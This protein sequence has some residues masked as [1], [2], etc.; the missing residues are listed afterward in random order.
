MA[1]RNEKT[2]HEILLDFQT[3]LQGVG[4]SL[5]VE[6]Q[7]VIEQ[8]DQAVLKTIIDDL[9]SSTASVKEQ[10][11]AL[12][13][14]VSKIEAV[15]KAGFAKAEKIAFAAGPE[16][17]KKAGATAGKLADNR[18]QILKKE[19]PKKKVDEILDYHPVDGKSISQWFHAMQ[20][21]DLERITQAVQ[22]ATVE[23]LSAS[24]AIKAIRGTKENDYKDGVLEASK[25]S[26]AM[27]ARTIVNGIAANAMLETCAENAEVI[28][29]VKFLA[30]LDAKTCP[31]CGAYDGTVWKPNELDKVK[32]PPLH[33][34]CRCVV[35]PYV[36]VKGLEG[37]RPA[38]NA[39]FDR[40][41]EEAY[42]KT[43]REKG[44]ERRYA[45]LSR[46]TRLRYYY[47][48]QKRFEKETGKPAYSRVSGDLTFK[49]Y[50]EKQPEEFK[51]SWLGPKRYELYSRG[52]YDPLQLANPDSGYLVPLEKLAPDQEGRK[53]IEVPQRK[54]QD[55]EE[56][57]A[58]LQVI[59][60]LGGSTAPVLAKDARGKKFVVKKGGK[61]GGDPQG[62]V[63]NEFAAD[64]FYRA[65]G[66]KV[67]GSRLY[68]TKDG[69]VL[70]SEYLDDG[71]ELS[72]WWREASDED[73]D[74]MLYRLR[75][76]LAAD[77]LIGNSDVIG[78]GADNI[79]V[80]KNGVPWRIDNGG[81]LG[82]TSKGQRKADA[83]WKDGYPDDLWTMTGRGGEIGRS[84][85]NNLTDY[86]QDLSI[87]V[88]ANAIDAQNWDA[89]IKAL[90]P[91][92]Q[93]I[94]RKRLEHVKKLAARGN[95][96]TGSGHSR[97][98]SEQILDHSYNLTKQRL[99][100]ILPDKIDETDTSTFAGFRTG[101]TAFD[102]TFKKIAE[103][104]K[105]VNL[106]HN[107][108]LTD[109]YQPPPRRML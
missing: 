16:I 81:S 47:D 34:N 91:E 51:R 10:M 96:F 14:L 40:L 22:R 50:F 87:L 33:P 83:D 45:D 97:D 109:Y 5:A 8:T 105:T 107:A 11:Q 53:P 100:D 31:F 93:E 98:Y 90:P 68:E 79:L 46:S 9:P 73:R 44:W 60:R 24:N 15:R 4:N 58:S 2:L 61:A 37:Q 21:K 59:Q 62:H 75:R 72:Q 85:T 104:A 82:Y 41:A 65:A 48:A 67:P 57:L 74:E 20:T 86:L 42:N 88:V 84:E 106:S 55:D 92:D 17:V 3:R 80:D 13:G 78:Q 35:I 101:T 76:G 28:D 12:E 94:V 7:K 38:A 64:Q 56:Y 71:K 66:V 1:S 89:A 43:A 26:A 69:P 19:L 27:T 23:G 77:I 102:G 103:A 54:R 29:G 39:D 36:D 99:Q 95:D 52:G 63:R 6:I 49:D 25:Q 32:R 18:G 70:L 108:R 30:T